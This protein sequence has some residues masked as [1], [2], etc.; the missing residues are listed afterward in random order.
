MSKRKIKVY[1]RC[2]A[3]LEVRLPNEEPERRF[4]REKTWLLTFDQE[5][6]MTKVFPQKI[7][8]D[9]L[10]PGVLGR[11]SNVRSLCE[12]TFPSDPDNLRK[13]ARRFVP[14][15]ILMVQQIQNEFAESV[16]KTMPFP[17]AGLM[18]E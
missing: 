5:V 7:G 10:V 4:E 13:G 16:G 18:E 8:L 11:F 2:R 3:W 12:I 9:A 6:W 17:D 1:A 14:E 15:A